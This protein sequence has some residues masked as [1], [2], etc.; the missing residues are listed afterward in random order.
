MAAE[1]HKSDG[2]SRLEETL[3]AYK[4]VRTRIFSGYYFPRQRLI[5]S[6]LC[7]DLGINR[8]VVREILKRLVLEGLVVMEPFKGCSV[9]DVSMQDAYE[10]YQVEAALEGFA[11]YLAVGRMDK[12]DIAELEMLIRESNEID[13]N[14][15]EEWV[16]Y[17]RKI[18]SLVNRSCGNRKLI[19]FIK[20][21]VQFSN[22]WFIVLSTS[23]EIPKR[24]QEHKT[25]LGAIK[26]KDA[27]KARRLLE[28]HIMDAADS[29]RRRLQKT[30]PNSESRE[31]GANKA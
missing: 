11:A 4:T 16:E 19:D 9:A 7:E 13:P 17:N 29:I 14:E 1:P 3:D 25:I 21:N 2:F 26:A 30:L 12:E 18:H 20:K 22:Y 27:N 15:V 31:S 5:E 8:P 23:G 28:T 10:T 24:N 6:A